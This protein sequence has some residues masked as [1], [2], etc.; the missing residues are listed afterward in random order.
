ML[1]GELAYHRGNHQEGLI[2]YAK[3]CNVAML[4][5]TRSPGP[6]CIRRVMRSE[7][8]LWAGEYDEAEQV[9]RDDLGLTD[10]VHRCAQHPKNMWA[11]HGLVEC[12]ERRKDADEAAQ[13][14]KLLQEASAATE[15]PIHSSVAVEGWRLKRSKSRMRVSAS[16]FSYLK[17]PL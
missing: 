16:R 14:K 10:T 12:L 9:Y 1:L 13:F 17:S 2:I 3:R 11:L 15:T 7:R 4:F 5:T 6:G 8:F